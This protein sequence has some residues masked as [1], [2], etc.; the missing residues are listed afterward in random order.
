MEYIKSFG[1]FI[2][3]EYPYDDDIISMLAS[4]HPNNIELGFQLVKGL[5]KDGVEYGDGLRDELRK[6]IGYCLIHD[7]EI[8][9]IS[10]LSVWKDKNNDNII[11]PEEIYKMKKLSV[12]SLYNCY[13]NGLPN[14]IDK[15]KLDTISLIDC[16]LS[17]IPDSIA[18]IKSLNYLNLGINKIKELPD[19]FNKLINLRSFSA[20][21]NNISGL[22]N[23][24]HD[25]KKLSYINLEDNRLNNDQLIKLYDSFDHLGDDLVL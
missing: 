15:V 23:G 24:F 11:I 4:D 17:S 8:D 21:M 12:I 1:N 13:I 7:I 14:N 9:Y 3:E 20:Y 22:P 25:M 2:L 6:H 16:N 19:K 18:N 5:I 10:T